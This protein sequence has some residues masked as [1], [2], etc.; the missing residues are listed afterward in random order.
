MQFFV[1]INSKVIKGP[2][3]S[4]N[5]RVYASPRIV[6]ISLS[7][8][9]SCSLFPSISLTLSLYPSLPPSYSPCKHSFM[10]RDF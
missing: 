7:H 1:A 2:K 5:F 4:S 9:P 6:C 10:S 8:S 3:C